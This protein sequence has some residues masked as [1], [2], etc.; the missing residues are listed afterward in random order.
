MARVGLDPSD[1]FVAM[2][3]AQP[4]AEFPDAWT[5]DHRTQAN[6]NLA[7]GGF[8]YGF[9][10]SGSPLFERR[11]PNIFVRLKRAGD[12]F[13]GFASTDGSNWVASSKPTYTVD[14]PAKLYVG[15]SQMSAPENERDS[16]ESL[17]HFRGLAG[18]PQAAAAK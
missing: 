8:D 15:L 16:V 3:A 14:Y 11:L 10:N 2:H 12:T 18:F 4:I 1:L 5:F 9:I 13:Y 7:T 17:T 6:G